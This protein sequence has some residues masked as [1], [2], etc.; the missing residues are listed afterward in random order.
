M[1]FAKLVFELK[2]FTQEYK[3]LKLGIKKPKQDRSKSTVDA[4]LEAVTH[5]IDKE[6]PSGLNTNKIAERAGVSVGSL[7]QYFKNKESI[8]EAIILRMTEKNLSGFEQQVSQKSGEVNIRSIIQVVVQSQFDNIQ[9]MGKLSNV[10]FE[11]APQVLSPSHFK[12][13]DERIIKFLMDKTAEFKIELRPTNVENAFFICAQ[14]VRGVMF[15]TV[16]SRLP[17]E[18]QALMDELVDMLTIYLEKK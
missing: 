14:A 12:K 2:S 16:L 5:I 4:I 1:E 11:Y 13:A 9:S 15:M 18:R 8:I 6:G 17:E 10:L 7:Y 3:M